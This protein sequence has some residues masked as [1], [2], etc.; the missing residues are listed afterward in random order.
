MKYQS[1]YSQAHVKY[2]ANFLVSL[3]WAV[4]ILA[5]V[6]GLTIS[7]VMGLATY[8]SFEQS[9][10]A[11]FVEGTAAILVTALPFILIA[12]VELCKIPLVF[13]FMAVKSMFWRILFLAFV[14]FLCLITFETMFNGFERNFANLNRA[15]DERGVENANFDQEKQLLEMRRA[16]ILKFTEDELLTEVDSSRRGVSEQFEA[17]TEE[18]NTRLRQQLNAIDYSFEDEL[19]AKIEELMQIRDG[20]YDAWSADTAM[21]EERFS[22]MLLGNIAGSS[23][24]RDRLLSELEAL[25]REFEEERAAAGF[26]TE[27]TVENR[28]RALIADKERQLQAITLGYLGGDALT[29][30]AQ[31]EDRL[32]SQMEFVNSKYERRIK[33]L[34][35]RID[36]TK[37]EILDRFA[38][39]EASESAAYAVAARDRSEFIELR[40]SELNSIQTYQDDKYA[41]LDVMAEQSFGI[42]EQI[43]KL[44]SEVLINDAEVRQLINQ[45]QIYRLAM[46]AYNVDEGA[47]VDKHM[48]GTIALIWFGSLS[49]ITAVTGVM[50]ALAGFYLRRFVAEDRDEGSL[51]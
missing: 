13:A 27:T 3:A 28:Y 38:E 17:Q 42:D 12:I 44:N 47:D 7:V 18:T 10:G 46:Y 15:I 5:V 20:Y 14:L 4:E 11:G 24:E 16:Q 21:V 26:F 2:Y 48:L 8:N 49:I 31:M 36:A 32:G 6:I 1:I 25:K 50:L 41:E 22:E 30:Q 33:E 29:K 9:G 43:F 37:Q 51:A 23:D 34:N 35:E 39:N 45:N 19:N 40:E